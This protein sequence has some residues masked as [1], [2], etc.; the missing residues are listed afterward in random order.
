M[1][2]MIHPRKEAAKKK[3]QP[4]D[5]ILSYDGKESTVEGFVSAIRNLESGKS[6]SLEIVRDGKINK[7]S[8]VRP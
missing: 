4:G 8:I 5:R 6:L 3:L 7:V 1:I 2:Y